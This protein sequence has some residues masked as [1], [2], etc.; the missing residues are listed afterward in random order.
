[1]EKNNKSQFGSLDTIAHASLGGVDGWDPT[2]YFNI[3][4]VPS[5]RFGN[6]GFIVGTSTFPTELSLNP[7]LDG[8]Y[9]AYNFFG[10]VGSGNA[11]YEG[12]F[13][14]SE[15]G[16]WL[17]LYNTYGAGGSVCSS[18]SVNDTPPEVAIANGCPTFPLMQTIVVDQTVME[19]CLQTI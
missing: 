9:M 13:P 4:V 6:T 8:I 18:D 15:A 14:V 5:I 7:D 17:N 11:I 12:K 10:T 2:R 3:W 1:M 19:Q 16:H